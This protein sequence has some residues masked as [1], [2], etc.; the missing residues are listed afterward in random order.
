[1]KP[2]EKFLTVIPYDSILVLEKR[3]EKEFWLHFTVSEKDTLSLRVLNTDFMREDF[4]SFLLKQKNLFINNKKIDKLKS[5]FLPD[6]G[7]CLASD[8][9]AIELIKVENFF[10]G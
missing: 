1:M 10:K 6:F 5:E 9:I 4:R 2:R 7:I 8:S 3:K